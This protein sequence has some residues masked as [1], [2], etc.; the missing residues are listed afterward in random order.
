MLPRQAITFRELIKEGLTG[1]QIKNLSASLKL[2]PTPFK[3]IYYVPSPEEKK[4]WFIDK[5]LFILKK[6]I[7]IY[8]I[9]EKFYFS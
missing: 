8:L 3:G 7:Q 1:P 4:A 6:I 2:F 5:P 9:T